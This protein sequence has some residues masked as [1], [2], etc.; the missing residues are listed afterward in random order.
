[1]RLLHSLLLNKAEQNTL[2]TPLTF[3]NKGENSATVKLTKTGTPNVDGIQYRLGESG[4]WQPY[5]IGTNITLSNVGDYVQFQDLNPGNISS[6]NYRKFVMT[7]RIAASGN[8]QSMLNYSDICTEHCYHRMFQGCSSLTTAP[9]LPATTL[10]A[11]CYSY[12]FSGC[13]SLTTAP[14]LPATTLTLNCYSY[15]FSSCSS[16]TTAPELPATT[17]ANECYTYMFQNCKLLTSAPE[18]PATNLE[19]YCCYYMFSG[20]S[21]LTTAPELPATSLASH[22]YEGMFYGC[23]KLTQ[24]P[25]ILPATTLADYC[26]SLM[27]ENCDSLTTAPEL[28][29]TTLAKCCYNRMFK[30]CSNLSNIKVGF[31]SWYTTSIPTNNWVEGVAAHG[32]FECPEKLYLEFGIHGIPDG[33]SVNGVGN[34]IVENQTLTQPVNDPVNFTP[35]YSLYPDGEVQFSIYSGSLPD[36]LTLN[37]DGSITGKASK[38]WEGQIV[39]QIT[40]ENYFAKTFTLT[41]SLLAEGVKVTPNNL[42]SNNSNPDFV[43]EQRSTAS[44]NEAWKAM[45]GNITTYAK[46][47]YQSGQYDWWQ[48][49]FLKPVSVTKVY[50]KC[51]N[52]D[53]NT[54]TYLEYSDDGTT[55]SRYDETEIPGTAEQTRT[56]EQGVPHRYYRFLSIQANY[57][58]QFYEIVFTYIP[59]EKFIN[60][61]E[62]VRKDVIVGTEFS[63]QIPYEKYPADLEVNFEITEGTLPEGVTFDNTTGIIQGTF[64]EVSEINL[65]ISMSAEGLESKSTSLTLKAVEQGN[66]PDDAIL[67]LDGT[68]A[69]SAETGQ[70]FTKNGSGEVVSTDY[71]DY[72]VLL[73]QGSPVCLVSNS[74]DDQLPLNNDDR[75]ISLWAKPTNNSLQGLVSYGQ[76]SSNKAWQFALESNCR[77]KIGGSNYASNEY[78]SPES[79]SAD[80]AWNDWHHYLINKVDGVEYL[81][82]DNILVGSFNYSRRTAS[83]NYVIGAGQDYNLTTSYRFSGYMTGI[84]MFN[85]S[86]SEDEILALSQEYTF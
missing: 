80:L 50:F 62:A 11:N 77:L 2:T 43:V 51:Q 59:V 54:K 83:G 47:Q 37:S 45:D 9:E 29:A 56:Y 31:T 14:E 26:Y 58:I 15:M 72:K 36:G 18:L 3:T 70:L 8:I 41:I 66:L 34:I 24:A 17:L 84:R 79:A 65:T 75:C 67:Y 4:G 52:E 19:T 42:T 63:Y 1:M 64:N 33:W 5:T 49:D 22:C 25:A 46:T 27:F 32:D 69:S 13:S 74:V 44:S 30:Y 7:G 81:Y 73:F 28:P 35:Q 38:P 82:I 20:C 10:A 48:I 78:V 85:R 23:G 12:M 39:I 57:Y 61:P 16:L 40:G 71:G 53:S 86:L 6:T 21:S 55:F 60:M 76:N 68:S